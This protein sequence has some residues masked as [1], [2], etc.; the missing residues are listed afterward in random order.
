MCGVD[1]HSCRPKFRKVRIYSRSGSKLAIFMRNIPRVIQFLAQHERIIRRL[2]SDSVQI[3][4][5]N[6]N[7][8]YRDF[9]LPY[10]DITT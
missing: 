9:F 7:S 5:I 8:F 10:D 1:A 2:A 6:N 4:A 3:V